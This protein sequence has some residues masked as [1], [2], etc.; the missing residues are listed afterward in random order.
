MLFE[1]TIGFLHVLDSWIGGLA[2]SFQES[3]F[4]SSRFALDSWLGGIGGIF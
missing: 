3:Y 2:E 4:I 1:E